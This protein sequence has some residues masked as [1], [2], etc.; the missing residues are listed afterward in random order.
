[1]EIILIFFDECFVM[2]TMF[3]YLPTSTGLDELYSKLSKNMYVKKHTDAV[4]KY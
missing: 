4:S 2:I 3:D 1:M